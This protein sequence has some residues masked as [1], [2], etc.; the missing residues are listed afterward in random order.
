MTERGASPAT[1]GFTLVEVLVALMIVAV[2]TMG[3]IGATEAYIDNIAAS[4]KRIIAQ[5]VAENKVVEMTI[6]ED[7]S[8]AE[9]EVVEML[10]RSWKVSVA[11]RPS[12]EPQLAAYAVSVGELNAQGSLLNMDFFVQRSALN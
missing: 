12:D 8:P 4:E 3:L 2:A 10:D 6:G 7:R 5:W 9:Y 11:A 1:E